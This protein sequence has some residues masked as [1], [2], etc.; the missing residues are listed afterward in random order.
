MCFIVQ[1]SYSQQNV[2]GWYW[3][4]GQPQSQT[5]NAIQFINS[6][7]IVAVGN[8]G[9]FMK[10]TDGGDTW[11]IN[12]Q[13]GPLQSLTGGGDTR[14][15]AALHFFDANTGLVGGT[16]LSANGDAI[17]RTT[18]GGL[19]FNKIVLGAGSQSV[20]G[21]YF[22][23]ANT[24]Y[25]CG[26][27]TTR[28]FKTTDA[29]LTW[30]AVSNVPS[31][32]YNA[33]YAFNENKIFI[34][35]SA[36]RIV[37]TTD[38]GS[39]WTTDT[40]P[41]STNNT[42]TDIDF[43]N[44]NTGYVT[45]NANYFG[46]TT[47]GGATWTQSVTPFGAIG[48][49]ALSISGNDVYT[50][51]DYTV[52]YKTTDDGLSWSTINFIDGSNP[53]QPAPFVI[54][55]LDVSGNDI[56][57][58]GSSG[59]LNISNDLGSTWRNKNYS[60]SQNATTFSAIWADSP[61]GK[62]WAGGTPGTIL[63]SSN[64]GNN[65]SEQPS[66]SSYTVNNIQFLNSNTGFFVSGIST[67]LNGRLNKTTNGGTTWFDIPL[68]SPYSAKAAVDVD[69]VDENTGWVLG[70]LP[71]QAGGGITCIKTT[72]GGSTWTQQT[73][74]IGYDFVSVSIDM[75]DANTGYFAAGTSISLFKTT[76]GGTN[77]NRIPSSPGSST[78]NKVKAVSKDVVFVSSSSGNLYKS[79]NGG[80]T[81]TNI[82]VPR[83]VTVFAMDWLDEYNGLV[84]GT[85]GFLAK[86]SDGGATWDWTNSGGST[87]RNVCMRNKDSVFAVSDINGSW[88]MFRYFAASAKPLTLL[89]NVGIQGFWNGTTQVSDTIS[90]TLRNQNSPFN[91][92]DQSNTV[93]YNQ[94]SG[95]VSF[96][97][98]SAG[99]YYIQI[100]HRN[101]L[102]TWSSVPMTM[103]SNLN[104]YD[105]TTSS[106]QAYGNNTVLTSGRYCDYSGDVNQEG[107]IDLG[108][109]VVV[110]NSSSVFETGYVTPDVN[111]DELVDLSD[112]IITL[113][114]ASIFVVKIT[115]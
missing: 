17:G 109:V 99:T 64:G 48:Q 89:L 77:W 5:L 93:I 69:F 58:G 2:N 22:L 53:Y 6:A 31:N 54:Y 25:A 51:G 4:N 13:A 26:N 107:N 10:S 16:S 85:S 39:T 61:S 73:N 52:I 47:D 88:Q 66:N 18:D 28:L 108:D 106:S 86:T 36:R 91:V 113:N 63:Y 112:L 97:T 40:V 49:R 37:K 95:T 8:T 104:Q 21:F 87:I 103:G 30:A 96:S 80:D 3:M 78:Y 100:N 114:N 102:E 29:G 75:L 111:G 15:L 12:S 42:L 7:E 43:K 70:G 72:N 94:G 44:A 90:V 11:L 101:S 32:T 71:L 20:T 45:G 67:Q 81:W 57:V 74:D 98:A 35:T 34:V 46:V 68:P 38:A 60:V 83:P 24:G 62:I 79:T 50:A 33:V 19:T 55:C 110:N 115:P 14:N 41:G 105:F 9:C 84:G 92:V 76:N 1:N 82:T 27:T 23:N 65:W 59:M 56:V